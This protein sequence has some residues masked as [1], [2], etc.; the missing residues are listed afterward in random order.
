AAR[1]SGASLRAAVLDGSDLT[2]TIARGAD[3][4]GA[5]IVGA[6]VHVAENEPTAAPPAA[7]QRVAPLPVVAET[8]PCDDAKWPRTMRT[9]FSGAKLSGA[10]LEKAN[11]TC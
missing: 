7:A 11:L 2:A 1:L 4:S 5:S 3:F 10:N 8:T 6:M 9:D